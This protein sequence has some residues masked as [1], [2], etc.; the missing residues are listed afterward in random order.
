MVIALRLG[1][2]YHQREIFYDYDWRTKWEI[3][4]LVLALSIGGRIVA[5]VIWADIMNRLGSNVMLLSHIQYY[6]TARVLRRIP[7]KYGSSLAEAI[8]IVRMETPL[9]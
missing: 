9:A 8:S 4:L 7:V 3:I 1:L 6:C 2:L 5:G